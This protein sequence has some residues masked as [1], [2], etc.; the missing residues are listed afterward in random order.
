MK[1]T[2]PSCGKDMPDGWQAAYCPTCDH[3]LFD[4][5]LDWDPPKRA[6]D[7]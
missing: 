5:L 6:Y 1:P 4:V 2:C 7:D 3:I